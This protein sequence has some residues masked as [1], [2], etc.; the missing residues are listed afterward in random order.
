MRSYEDPAVDAGGRG[1]L[2]AQV[3]IGEGGGFYKEVGCTRRRRGEEPVAMVSMDIARLAGEP[4]TVGK[5][6]MRGEAGNI[7][8]DDS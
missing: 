5:E 7:S 2:P 1:V 8:S 4:L 6:V 3:K